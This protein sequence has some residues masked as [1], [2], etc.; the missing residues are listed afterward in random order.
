MQDLLN[1]LKKLQTEKENELLSISRLVTENQS[2]YH[3]WHRLG[4]WVNIQQKKLLWHLIQLTLQLTSGVGSG[5]S[6][7]QTLIKMYSPISA[8][9]RIVNRLLD[10][11]RTTMASILQLV[12]AVLWLVGV[13]TYSLLMTRTRN[14]MQRWA[15][16]MFSYRLGNGFSPVPFSV[17]CL[18]VLLLL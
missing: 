2:S 11:V 6:W 12:L 5:I 1:C 3:I 8:C 14:K 9:K 17:L 15:N 16:R 10:G 13:P 4:F 7:A 18:V